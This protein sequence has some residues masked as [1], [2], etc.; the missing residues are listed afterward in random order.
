METL[1]NDSRK[2]LRDASGSLYTAGFFTNIRGN[3]TTTATNIVQP[4]ANECRNYT[5][6][7]QASKSDAAQS[8]A[9]ATNLSNE[10]STRQAALNNV[11]QSFQRLSTLDSTSLQSLQRTLQQNRERFNASN[12][13]TM[14]I[15]LQEVYRNQQAV[16]QGQRATIS[17]LRTE[18][19]ET[20]RAI[21]DLS[22]LQGCS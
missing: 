11:V 21:D 14:L 22:T 4:R 9:A 3:V 8:L 5:S 18:I 20:K 6:Q 1:L 15:S 17:R 7:A 12:V 19:A 16:L 2:L 10:A 13:K